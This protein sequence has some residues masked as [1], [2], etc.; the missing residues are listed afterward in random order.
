MVNKC[1][2]LIKL[3]IRCV[4][5]HGFSQRTSNSTM[6]TDTE[7]TL[8]NSRVRGVNPLSSRKSTRNLWSASIYVV[9]QYL[10]LLGVR[11]FTSADLINCKS[12]II[13]AF[14]LEKN[15]HISGPT[16]FQI[17]VVQGLTVTIKNIRHVS[18]QLDFYD[19][20]MCVHTQTYTESPPV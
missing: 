18:L 4:T 15:S 9:P 11:G 7:L 3:G 19:K 16:Q 17:H 14:T 5:V 1:L 6:Q 13:A 20:L 12:C 8:D 2:L 10:Q